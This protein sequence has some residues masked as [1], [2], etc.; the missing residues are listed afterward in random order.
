MRETGCRNKPRN[1]RAMQVPAASTGSRALLRSSHPHPLLQLHRCRLAQGLARQRIQCSKLQAVCRRSEEAEPNE[2]GM[3]QARTSPSRSWSLG[4]AGVTATALVALPSAVPAALA[5]TVMEEPANA[6]SL[7]TWAIHVSSVVST[8]LLPCL[9]S[10]S[11]L[12]T[13]SAPAGVIQPCH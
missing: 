10:A 2:A 6:L 3:Q 9:P 13:T 1:S 12:L 7:P 8:A 11:N 4:L 5:L